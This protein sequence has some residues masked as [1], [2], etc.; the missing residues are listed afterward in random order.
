MAIPNIPV[1]KF[2]IL[3]SHL[4]YLTSFNK[5]LLFIP[6]EISVGTGGGGGA[7]GGGMRGGQSKE[8]AAAVG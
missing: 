4:V 2:S 3:L 5:L 6:R 8:L 7:G 1:W